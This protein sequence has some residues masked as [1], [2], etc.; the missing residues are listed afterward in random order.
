M[1]LAKYEKMDVYVF[2]EKITF[3]RNIFSQILGIIENTENTENMKTY[4]MP[5][6]KVRTRM[7]DM[8]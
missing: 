1:V 4:E 8:K 5:M 6:T 7:T 3:K 2:I